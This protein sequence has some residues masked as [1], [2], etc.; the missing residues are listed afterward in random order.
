MSS[1][2]GKPLCWQ[3][4]KFKISNLDVEDPKHP[5]RKIRPHWDRLDAHYSELFI[6]TDGS[7]LEEKVGASHIIR[8]RDK[9]IF[10]DQ[11]RLEDNS[12]VFQVYVWAIKM[13]LT[14][15]PKKDEKAEIFIDNQAALRAVYNTY[16]S[17]LL[18]QDAQTTQTTLFKLRKQITLQWIKTHIEEAE[19]E[20]A[21]KAAKEATSLNE[22]YVKHLIKDCT[23]NLWQAKWD[24]SNIE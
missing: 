5:K 11:Q 16:H 20:E 15:L 7:K 17:K 10:Q 23:V 1:K 18:V 2:A 12:C 19:N 13:A 6:Y 4:K 8:Y 9:Q 14:K 24:K 3:V 22:S 21:D